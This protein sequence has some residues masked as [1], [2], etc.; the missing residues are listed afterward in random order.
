MPTRPLSTRPP[1]IRRVAGLA[2]LVTVALVAL[3][4][5]S[6]GSESGD[7]AAEST[8]TTTAPEAS[9][10]TE[11]LVFNGQGNH[12]DAY[13]VEPDAG[14]AFPTQRVVESAATDSDGGRDINAQICFMEPADGGD[15]WFISGEDTNQDEPG[16]S[17]GWGIFRL[18]GTELGD[19]R[20]TQLGKL[21]PTG[22]GSFDPR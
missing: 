21:V 11:P 5:C 10:P 16:G 6:E 15:P 22:E 4:S 20:A 14:G 2:A 18:E 12:L 8:T 9:G 19:L 1:A 3:G 13:A 17:A 7:T